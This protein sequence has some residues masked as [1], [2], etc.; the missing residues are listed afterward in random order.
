MQF[1]DLY[2]SVCFSACKGGISEKISFPF[3]RKKLSAFFLRL[4]ANYLERTSGY[5]NFGSVLVYRF[6]R[7]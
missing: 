5:P 6:T 7:E 1:K 2:K 4:E 3:Y